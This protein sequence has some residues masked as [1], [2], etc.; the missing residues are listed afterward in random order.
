M[1]TIYRWYL[2]GNF[3][4]WDSNVDT[5]CTAYG[6]CGNII[7]DTNT[8]WIQNET[9]QVDYLWTWGANYSDWDTA[10]QASLTDWEEED[11]C[12]EHDGDYLNCIGDELEVDAASIC[13]YCEPSIDHGN[14]VGLTDDDHRHYVLKSEAEANYGNITEGN[15]S[16]DLR[17]TGQTTILG[18]TSIQNDELHIGNLTIKEVDGRIIFST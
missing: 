7:R 13:T 11:H 1:T 3:T 17:I 8:T 15:W 14:L 2:Q 9:E 4:T 18:N 16:N 10:Y 12:D 5:N 6:S